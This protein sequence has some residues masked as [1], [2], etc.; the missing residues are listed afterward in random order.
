MP[1]SLYAVHNI[2]RT[3][4]RPDRDLVGYDQH[5]GGGDEDIPGARYQSEQLGRQRPGGQGGQA[6]EG[7]CH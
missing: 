2:S 4:A 6:Q 5:P 7:K 3:V 1:L